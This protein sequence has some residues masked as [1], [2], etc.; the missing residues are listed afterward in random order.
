MR[1]T[2]YV[3][4]VLG[5]LALGGCKETKETVVVPGGGAKQTTK[6]TTKE[7]VVTPGGEASKSTTTTTK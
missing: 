1:T 2:A 4:L 3:V 6:E 7:T 5:A